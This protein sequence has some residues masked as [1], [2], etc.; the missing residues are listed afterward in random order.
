M[1]HLSYFTLILSVA[2]SLSV[3][4]KEAEIPVP[5]PVSDVKAYP[6]INRAKVEF[7]VPSDAVSYKVF[8]SK[9]KYAQGEVTNP[10]EI[11]SVI[12]EDLAAGE[13]I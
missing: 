8:H 7:A 3:G 2:A 9:G 10:S 1:K 6:G 4:C 13:N 11:Q 5:D 12:V